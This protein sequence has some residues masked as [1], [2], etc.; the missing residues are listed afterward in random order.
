MADAF[1]RHSVLVS[2]L[3][4]IHVLDHGVAVIP[5]FQCSPNQGV[6]R[7]Y[8]CDA[9]IT[10]IRLDRNPHSAALKGTKSARLAVVLFLRHHRSRRTL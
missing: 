8:E 10:V 5:Q 6:I 2:C 9:R 1:I 7:Q 4:K 3:T